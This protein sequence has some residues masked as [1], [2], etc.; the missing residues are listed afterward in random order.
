LELVSVY[1][2][3][4]MIMEEGA[5]FVD[6]LK[7]MSEEDI[8]KKQLAIEQIAPRLQYAVVSILDIFHSLSHS[9]TLTTLI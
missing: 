4:Q 5:N 3:K 9:L 1:I 6:I 7:A 2:P 8:L